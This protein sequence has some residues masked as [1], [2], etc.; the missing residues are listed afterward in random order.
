MIDIFTIALTHGLILAA[1][2]RLLFRDDLDS[3]DPDAAK[4]KRPWLKN[5]PGERR[6]A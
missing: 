5:E 3:G 2:W 4:T 1:C 6:D